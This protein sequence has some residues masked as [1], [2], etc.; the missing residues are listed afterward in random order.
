M[1]RKVEVR[2]LDDIDGSAADET[3]AFALDGVQYE[4]DL[5]DKNARL[6][7]EVFA[8]FTAHGR[9]AGRGAV[10]VSRRRGPVS[11]A[12]NRQHSQAIREW[13]RRAGLHLADR[14]RIPQEI[15]DRYEAGGADATGAAPAPAQVAPPAAAKPAR[16]GARAAPPAEFRSADA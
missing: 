10:A 2:L 12:D 9:R 6:L 14:G 11:R 13:A 15:V 8:E 1:A 4:I 5:S 3:V 7:R 16:R